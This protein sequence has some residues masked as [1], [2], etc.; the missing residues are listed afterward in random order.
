M[1]PI[2]N[3]IRDLSKPEQDSILAAERAAHDA[4]FAVYRRT[5][6]PQAALS[7]YLVAMKVTH[8]SLFNGLRSDGE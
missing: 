7:A 4:W 5:R 1:K 3:N 6:D 2:I 8:E